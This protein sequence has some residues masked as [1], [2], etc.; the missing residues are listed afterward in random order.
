MKKISISLLLIF[1]MGVVF[2]NCTADMDNVINIKSIAA[3]NVYVNILGRLIT[4]KPNTTQ[5]IKNIR[6]GTYSFS[7]NYDLPSGVT[8]SSVDGTASGDLTL[9]AGTRISIFYTSRIQA[10]TGGGAAGASAQ[11]NYILVA[12]I[13]SS[14][15]KTSSTS[16]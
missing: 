15:D 6:R 12:S 9:N 4:V 10:T 2:S 13:S 1:S 14:D 8:G 7:T 16:P 11:T 5:Q 3:E